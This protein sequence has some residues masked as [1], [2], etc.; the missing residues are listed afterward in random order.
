MSITADTFNEFVNT[1]Q[2]D[3]AKESLDTLRSEGNDF[4]SFTSINTVI[5]LIKLAL[6]TPSLSIPSGMLAGYY[7]APKFNQLLTCL[8]MESKKHLAA[9]GES[10][11]AMNRVSRVCIDILKAAS[12]TCPES[13]R[14]PTFH[15]FVEQL[16]LHRKFP[17]HVGMKG[18]AFE[19][20]RDLY[21]GADLGL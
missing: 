18:E 1:R 14:V 7:L 15:K 12:E 6:N 9:A 10:Q 8:P 17:R 4:K 11:E 16:L 21:F 19:P 2:Y 20:H 3:L 13:L 5:C